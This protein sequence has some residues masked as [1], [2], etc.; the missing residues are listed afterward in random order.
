[1][2]VRFWLNAK[3]KEALETERKL[4]HGEM[5]DVSFLDGIEVRTNDKGGTEYIECYVDPFDPASSMPSIDRKYV[6]RVSSVDT[7]R[8]GFRTDGIYKMKGATARVTSERGFHRGGSFDNEVHVDYYQQ[9]S[10]S[11][12]SV[13]T[14]REIYSKVRTGELKP[15]EDW[16]VPPHELEHREHRATEDTS[17]KTTN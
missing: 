7:Y 14:L 6:K 2:S 11:A 4:K 5:Q 1:M 10:I 16:S 13:K 8:E 3:G 12:G 17:T 15:V 9:I